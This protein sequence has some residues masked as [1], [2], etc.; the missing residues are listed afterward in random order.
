V[1]FEKVEFGYDERRRILHGVDFEVPAGGT[2][3]VVGHSGSGKSTLTRLLYRFYDVDAGRVTIDGRD[4]R[5]YSQASLRSA[6]AIVPQDTV[7]FNDTIFYNIRYGRTSSDLRFRSADAGSPPFAAGG[8]NERIHGF[9][10]QRGDGT[11]APQHQFA[12]RGGRDPA[13]GDVPQ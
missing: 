10:R 8:N 11:S 3:A 6:I 1:R 9:H 7:L 12:A 4:I 5:D 2:V 13:A